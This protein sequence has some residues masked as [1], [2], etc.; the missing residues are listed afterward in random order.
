M[1]NLRKRI[2]ARL[3]AGLSNSQPRN[4]S[5]NVLPPWSRYV[6]GR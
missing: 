1:V 6:A 4:G 5:G 2:V 3:G